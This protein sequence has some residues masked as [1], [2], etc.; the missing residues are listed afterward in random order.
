LDN[1][2][3]LRNPRS[4]DENSV[5]EDAV[6]W[7][8]IH[9]LHNIAA[10]PM[11]HLQP[12]LLKNISKTKLMEFELNFKRMMC[13]WSPDDNGLFATYAMSCLTYDKHIF[14]A[15]HLI[16]TSHEINPLVLSMSLSLDSRIK[17]NQLKSVVTII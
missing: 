16:T 5:V 6:F 12:D 3:F 13:S 7:E 14:E 8:I 10:L 4:L 2:C 17:L 11:Y 1:H 9:P 15:R